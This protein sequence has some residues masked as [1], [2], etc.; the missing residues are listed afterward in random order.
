MKNNTMNYQI[1]LKTQQIK[2]TGFS[3]EL[4]VSSVR[5]S[6][7]LT[8]GILNISDLNSPAAS[9][10]R[11]PLPRGVRPSTSSPVCLETRLPPA[12]RE[13]AAP[14]SSRTYPRLSFSSPLQPVWEEVKVPALP[15][16][17]EGVPQL[18]HVA[19][20]DA[21]LPQRVVCN[22]RQH[23]QAKQGTALQLPASARCRGGTRS[24]RDATPR[25]LPRLAAVRRHTQSPRRLS[26][27]SR[28]GCSGVTKNR[29]WFWK[30][31]LGNYWK[32]GVLLGKARRLRRRILLQTSAVCRGGSPVLSPGVSVTKSNPTQAPLSAHH[33]QKR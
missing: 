3:S 2:V 22:E 5:C 12:P 15:L 26:Y 11:T 21:V 6:Y 18:Q 14:R 17:Q 25:A 32:D 20:H 29:T 10:D 33:K 19:V 8:T 9:S 13:A 4:C 23:W 27:T 31:H 16:R 7:P 28:R 1:P 30:K 24:R